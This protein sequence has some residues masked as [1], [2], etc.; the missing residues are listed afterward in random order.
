MKIKRFY[1]F[2]FRDLLR[3]IVFST[4]VWGICQTIISVRDYINRPRLRVGVLPLWALSAK[5]I[6]LRD[7]G[8]YDPEHEITFNNKV[9]G[10]FIKDG[11]L[12]IF[13]ELKEEPDHFVEASRSKEGCVVLPI[14]IN[15]IGHDNLRDFELTMAFP[16]PQHPGEKTD[17]SIN[18]VDFS[19]ESLELKELFLRKSEFRGPG[20]YREKIPDENIYK[21][22]R[23]LGLT[24][25]YISVKGVLEGNNFQVLYLKL[26]V[27]KRIQKFA[28]V[29]Q[30]DSQQTY[31]EN[32]VFGQLVKVVDQ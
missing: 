18:V 14:L 12:N 25:D 7:I 16:E 15:N 21:I 5:K 31:F 28:V 10:V 17:S 9:F 4:T 11:G 6:T 30:T 24:E 22:Y 27:P 20:I 2:F 3:L 23:Q 26:R 19:S 1:R 8:V 13:E 29:F 32:R